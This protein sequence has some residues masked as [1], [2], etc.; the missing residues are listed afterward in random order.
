MI[1]YDYISKSISYYENCGYSRIESPWTVTKGISNITKPE[2]AK[3]F[4]ISEKDKVLVASGEQSFLSLYNKGFLPLGMYQSTTP[5]FRDESFDPLHTKYFIKNELIRT[6]KTD[7]KSLMEM[8][9]CVSTFFYQ[10]LGGDVKVVETY[11]GYKSYDIT[12]K[13][14]E[15]GSYGIRDCV[16]LKWIYG[17]GIAEPRFSRIKQAY[18]ISQ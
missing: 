15:L 17:T 2:G 12:Y 4:S 13:D 14:Q 9:D 16:F 1:N 11:M 10:L 7:E 8:I 3:D 6:D 5:C 18:G